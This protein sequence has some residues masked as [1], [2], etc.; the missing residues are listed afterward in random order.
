MTIPE[1]SREDF[2][3]IDKET[4]IIYRQF[5]NIYDFKTLDI[6]ENIEI[7]YTQSYKSETWSKLR[8]ISDGL[9]IE[10]LDDTGYIMRLVT[11]NQRYETKRNIKIGDTSEKVLK[12][13]GKDASWIGDKKIE[14][15]LGNAEFETMCCLTF[16]L[17]DGFVNQ[18]EITCGD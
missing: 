5:D 14:Y 9:I 18:I 1:I 15:C 6:K 2:S 4:A 10:W 7:L 11:D 17:K 12:A 8:K 13:Y 3:L 16:Y